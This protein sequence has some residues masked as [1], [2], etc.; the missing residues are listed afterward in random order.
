VVAE[1]V[2]DSGAVLAMVF[3]EPGAHV[4]WSVVRTS[5]IGAVNYAEVLSRMV[6]EGMHVDDAVYRL[7]RI[8]LGVVAADELDAVAVGSMFLKTRRTGTSLADRFF[9]ALARSTGLPGFTTDRRLAAL[10]V[11]AE[12]R[13]IR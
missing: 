11:G 7:A 8:G 13:L 4:A 1:A 3:D 10:D 6:E 12:V 9:L 5:V 2:L